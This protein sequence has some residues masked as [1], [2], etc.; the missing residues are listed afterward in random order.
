VGKIQRSIR[1]RISA[2][3]HAVLSQPMTA[4]KLEALKAGVAEV[5][6]IGRELNDTARALNGRERL[7]H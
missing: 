7:P 5:S 4:T 6:T 2:L 1:A 3:G